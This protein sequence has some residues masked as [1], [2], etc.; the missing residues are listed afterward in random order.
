[1]LVKHVGVT[2]LKAVFPGFDTSAR[3]FPGLI[4]A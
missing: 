4:R 3:R 1:V 2:D